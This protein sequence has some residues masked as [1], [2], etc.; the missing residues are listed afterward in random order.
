MSETPVRKIFLDETD[1]NADW[2]RTPRTRASER[3]IHAALLEPRQ[4][5]KPDKPTKTVVRK[6]RERVH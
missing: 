5:E 6:N 3:R 1:A 2:I 4:A